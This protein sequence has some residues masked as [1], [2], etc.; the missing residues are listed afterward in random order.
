MTTDRDATGGGS[1]DLYATL[2]VPPGAS[3]EDITRAYRRLAREHHPDVNPDAA[4]DAFAELTDAYDV[5]HDADRRRAYDGTRRA[6]TQAA[7]AAAG[8][9]I[10]IRH[11]TPPQQD[12]SS[13]RSGADTPP[14]RADPGEVELALTFDQAALG[15]TAVLPV[16]SELP[17]GSC[18]GGGTTGALHET[19]SPCGGAGFTTRKSGGITIRRQWSECGGT[20]RMPAVACPDCGGA[21][22]RRVTREVTVRVPAGVTDGTRLRIP[23]RGPGPGPGPSPGPSLVAVVRTSAH[24]YFARSGNDITLRLPIS[25]AEAALGGVVTVPTLTGAVAVRIPAGTPNGRTLRV[26]GRGIP[27]A[28]RPGDLL[29]T[30][31]VVVPTEL[32]D[33]QRA[34]L[35]A[36]AAATTG[37]PRGHFEVPAATDRT[38]EH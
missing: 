26:R 11:I 32:N 33:A 3:A 24:P 30:V 19:C 2:G 23:L 16:E 17:C 36:F 7:D 14:N 27:H 1:D 8:V 18:T 20:G 12:R 28:E 15:T 13:A 4:A 35:E 5:L 25:I 10:P 38:A 37:T 9:R 21:G 22:R 6:R 31:D 29:L 34:A